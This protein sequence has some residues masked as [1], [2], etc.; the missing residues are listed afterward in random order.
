MREVVEVTEV[1]DMESIK[2]RASASQG[3]STKKRLGLLRDAVARV[4]VG[5]ER[6]CERG[7]VGLK[8]KRRSGES[9]AKEMCRLTPK[10]P[11]NIDA[12][13]VPAETFSKGIT[14]NAATDKDVSFTR[15]NELRE[16]ALNRLGRR[17][18]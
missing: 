4:A 8:R 14:E 18:R 11:Q 17:W 12:H 9:Y 6:N 1:T 15:F 3:S 16:K 2:A 7:R 5:T 10:D 13:R